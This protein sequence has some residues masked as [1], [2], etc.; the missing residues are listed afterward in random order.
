VIEILPHGFIMRDLTQYD[1]AKRRKVKP[2]VAEPARGPA[3]R[4]GPGWRRTAIPAVC[5][6][7][8]SPQGG[9]NSRCEALSGGRWDGSR[10]RALLP[11]CRPSLGRD[12]V[13][14]AST[15]IEFARLAHFVAP[16]GP[17]AIHLHGAHSPPGWLAK[18]GPAQ[19]FR[20]HC[21]PACG[22]A[23][24]AIAPKS[25]KSAVKSTCYGVD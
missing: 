15:A 11:R 2:A 3:C 23:F 19:T 25:R 5:A 1:G 18:L 22:C 4:C 16:A 10:G 20:F 17:G 24:D 13:V 21:V 14:G 6:H 8:M 7:N 12:L 9:W